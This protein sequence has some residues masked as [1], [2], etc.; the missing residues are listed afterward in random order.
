MTNLNTSEQ[1]SGSVTLGG[2]GAE[3]SSLR[4]QVEG[5]KKSFNDYAQAT[6]SK[7]PEVGGSTAGEPQVAQKEDK[8]A[9]DLQAVGEKR[10]LPSMEDN[11]KRIKRRG[12]AGLKDRAET[13]AAAANAAPVLPAQH[14][15]KA[16]QC[17]S[18][19][20]PTRTGLRSSKHAT[21]QDMLSITN[22]ILNPF[23]DFHMD[24]TSSDRS[25]A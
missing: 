14:A 7:K 6:K 23:D 19:P 9:A 8:T 10:K 25:E 17:V 1:P 24:D 4:T 18:N 22:N 3:I 13:L 16:T 20:Q 2:Q 21:S 11:N 5:L 12:I 15:R